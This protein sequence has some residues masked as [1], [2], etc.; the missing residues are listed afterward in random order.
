MERYRAINK[1]YYRDASVGLLVFD[2]SN[3][4]SFEDLPSWKENFEREDSTG[5]AAVI[6]VGNKC[7]LTKQL[8][9]TEEEAKG[10]ADD[11]GADYFSAS[12]LS[13]EGILEL[14]QAIIMHLG[15]SLA[16]PAALEKVV[17]DIAQESRKQSNCC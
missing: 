2:M 1:I 13:G 3:R 7:D 12:A 14:R 5:S 9:V 16:R 15:P 10:F 17:T 8:Q 4:K 11:Q 6:I